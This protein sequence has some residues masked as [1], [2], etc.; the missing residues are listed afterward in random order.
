MERRKQ[1]R[2]KKLIIYT[3]FILINAIIIV[4]MSYVLTENYQTRKQLEL[5]EQSISKGF[6]YSP[7][8]FFGDEYNYNDLK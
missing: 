5:C 3:L 4:L 8:C 1:S 2:T 7:N 6:S